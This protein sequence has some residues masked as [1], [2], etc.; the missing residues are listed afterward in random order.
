M[1]LV[2]SLQLGYVLSSVVTVKTWVTPDEL[3]GA[4]LGV[5]PVFLMF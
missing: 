3:Y 5:N 2:H 4:D 1:K